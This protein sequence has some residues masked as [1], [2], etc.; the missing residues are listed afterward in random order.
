[1]AQQLRRRIDKWYYGEIKK[2][3]HNRRNIHKIEEASYRIGENLCQL[4]I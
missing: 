2:L 1:M 3:L 4:Y